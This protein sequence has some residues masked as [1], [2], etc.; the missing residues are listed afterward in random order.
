MPT[1]L[2]VV[3]AT[4]SFVSDNRPNPLRERIN[5]ERLRDHL[6]ARFQEARRQGGILSVARDEQHFEV[7]AAFPGGVS[8]LAPVQTRQTHVGDQEIDMPLGLKNL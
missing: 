6:H 2:A 8:E 4:R 3:S 7:A 1:N 5:G